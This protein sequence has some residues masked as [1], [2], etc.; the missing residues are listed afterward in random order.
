EAALLRAIVACPDEDTPRLVFADYL[1][2]LGTP[3]AAGRAEFIRLHVRAARMDEHDPERKAALCQIDQL[4][5]AWDCAWQRDPP[6]GV[7]PLS[8]YRRGFA[9]RASAP[10]SALLAVADDPRLPPLHAPTLTA[11]VGAGRR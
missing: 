11:D 6:S 10:A 3:A 9:F 1:D 4:L 7:R 5:C 8:G 2:E